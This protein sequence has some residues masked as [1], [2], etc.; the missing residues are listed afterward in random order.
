MQLG[1]RKDDPPS[2]SPPQPSY[3]SVYSGTEESKSFILNIFLSYYLAQGYLLHRSRAV[4]LHTTAL[5]HLS[6]L[7]RQ[8]LLLLYCSTE[9]V[10]LEVMYK[11]QEII[12]QTP[13]LKYV[14]R[15]STKL[16]IKCQIDIHS[17]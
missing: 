13:H 7:H 16:Q 9:L 12:Q 4:H 15:K 17:D 1:S 10:D 2:L 14:A 8:W 3:I 11:C 6:C 5:L